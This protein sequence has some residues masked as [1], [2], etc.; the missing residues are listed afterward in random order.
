M[1]IKISEDWVVM[2]EE[3]KKEGT[4]GGERGQEGKEKEKN[5]HKERERVYRGKGRECILDFRQKEP[6]IQK[7][8]VYSG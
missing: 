2:V 6:F 7:S 1:S 3:R 4:G 5:R 8:C